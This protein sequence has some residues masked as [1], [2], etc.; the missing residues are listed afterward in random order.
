MWNVRAEVIS[1]TMISVTMI[2]VT[3]ISVTIR[4]TG[5]I[6]KSIR[7][8]QSNIKEKHETKDLQKTA[9]FG[10]AHTHTAASADVKGQNIFRGR[11]NITYSTDYKYRRA[12]KICTL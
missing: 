10:T 11:N 8:Y 2:S 4:A 3:M 1:V 9:I 6:S 7:Q 5:T 12:A